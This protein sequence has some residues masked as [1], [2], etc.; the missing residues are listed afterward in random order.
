MRV[1]FDRL[2][3]EQ[4]NPRSQ[5]LDR[6]SVLEILE[7]IQQEDARVPR[8]VQAVRKDLAKGVELLVDRLK[9]GGRILLFG[10]GTS[11][12]LGVLEAAEC[13]PTF[14]TPPELVVAVMAGG[15]ECVWA[16]REGAEDDAKDG[17]LQLR[18]LCA[19]ERDAV[20]GIA[21]SGV[22]PFVHGALSEA[23]K[24]G[25]GRILVTCN[26]EGVDPTTADVVIAPRVGPEVITGSTRLKAGTA[27]KL[28]LNALTVATMV[29]LGKV[30]ENL[31][32]DLQPKSK[33]L[34]ARAHRI[35]RLLT[36][37]EE[38]AASRALR[39][40]RNR[41]KIAVVM[42]R[43]GVARRVAERLVEEAGGRLRDAMGER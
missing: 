39:A 6:L 15:P 2:L 33:K 42:L 34:K 3:T 25:A 28:V 5:K 14:D 17:A 12:R 8:A 26:R 20:I 38:P 30:Y 35:I 40:A 21:A 11:G 32:V 23:K 16:S 7:V 43:R 36:G 27:T 41:V 31:M 1:G 9:R 10:A 13:P 24:V 18:R 4:R 22:T 37:V 29:R 19:S